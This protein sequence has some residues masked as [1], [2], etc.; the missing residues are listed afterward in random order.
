MSKE[1]HYEK[2][3]DYFAEDQLESA[4]EELGR[5][6]D[7]YPE[8]GD[9]LHDLAMCYYHQKNYDQALEFGKR[10]RDVETDNPL[11]Y[12]ALSMF[13]VAKGMIEEAEEMGEKARTADGEEES[14]TVSLS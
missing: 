5:A 12:T 3:M 2:G 8:Y 1:E 9:V 4:I 13:Y 14:G 11:A 7:L 6:V 10:F